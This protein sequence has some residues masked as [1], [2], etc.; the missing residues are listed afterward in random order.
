MPFIIQKLIEKGLVEPSV[1]PIANKVQARATSGERDEALERAILAAIEDAS[2]QKTESQVVQYARRMRLHEIIEPG[3]ESLR[4]EIMR[5]VFLATSKNPRIVPDSLLDVLHLNHDQRPT[6]AA[7]LF[8]LHRRLS[9]LPDFQPLL[10]AARDQAVVKELKRMARD[11]SALARTVEQTPEGAAARVRVV[12]RAWNPEPYLRYLASECNRLRLSAIDPQY[13]TLTGESKITLVQ[14]YTDLEVETNVPIESDKDRRGK[15][16]QQE[17]AL[18]RERGEMR[19]LTALE[20]VSDKQSPRVVLLGAPGSGKSTFANYLTYCLTMAHLEPNGDWLTRLAGWTLGTLLPVRIVLRDLATWADTDA[21]RT[22]KPTAQ[23]LWNFIQHDLTENGFADSFEPLKRHLQERGGLVILDGLDEVPDANARREFVRSVMDSFARANGLCRFVVTCRPYAYRDPLWRLQD[24]TE[25]TLAPFSREQIASFV[26]RWCETVAPIQ[27]WSA[28]FAQTKASELIAA[29]E[30]PHL[31]K[32]ADRPL[33]LTL[34]AT[35][36]TSRGKLPDDRADLYEDCVALML[37][38]WQS[39][40]ETIVHGQKKVEDGVLTRLGISRDDLERALSRVAFEAH[41]RQ[42]ALQDRKPETANITGEELR[43]ALAPMLG[44]SR[45]RAD[46]VIYY[47]QTR[48]GLLAEHGMEV[49]TFPHRTFQ[50]F[51]AACDILNSEDFPTNLAEWVCA[52]RDWWREVFLLAA[53]RSRKRNFGQA[54]ALINA[55]CDKEYRAGERITDTDA[56][57]AAL[58]AQAAAD[59]HLSERAH[60][61]GLYQRTLR[62]LQNWLVGIIEQGALPLKE[63]AEVGRILSALG[64]PRP[65]VSCPIP[66]LV[67]VPPGKFVMGEGEEQHRVTLP[68]FRVGKYPVTNAQYRR[69][70]EDGGYSDKHRDCWTDAGWEWRKKENVEKPPYLDN[71]EWN[72]ANHPVVTVSWYEAVAYCN[73][74]TKT[75]PERRHFRLPTEA[76]WEKA[77]RGNEG[78]EYPWIGEFDKEK[79]N[80]DESGIGRTTAVGLFSRGASPYGALDVAGNVWEWCIGL[81]KEYPYAPNDGREDLQAKGTRCL[82]GGSWLDARDI[83]RCASRSR[84]PPVARVDFVGFRVAES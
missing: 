67:P 27:G 31:A 72:A 22:R 32:L 14:V 28:V 48:A 26:K 10:Q 82:R 21:E 64:D 60:S 73:W 59:V 19:H 69:F 65:D 47:I 39:G 2:Q 9:V 54:V 16:R 37:D 83:A 81:Y 61:P 77:A 3:N 74:L 84:L 38:Y 68:E 41:Q 8:H 20:A 66:A 33:L 44:N 56:S 13:V 79:A 71:S 35:L 17:I 15:S 7:L 50:E 42:G 6:L 30:L 12:D 40:K 36:H 34:M 49:Y 11:L 58:A 1:K 24:F 76:E 57:A 53:G 70:V 23:T 46:M 5:L 18:M 62:K 43:R 80:T 45:D 29:T 75:D 63:R 25:H 55:L 78:R 52:D 4:D 51:L